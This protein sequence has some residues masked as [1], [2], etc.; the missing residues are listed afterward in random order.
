M[1]RPTNA[2]K[3]LAEVSHLSLRTIMRHICGE[4]LGEGLFRD[5]YVMKQDKRF[6]VKV[7]RDMSTGM[8]ANAT[9]WRNYVDNHEDQ[10]IGPWLAP[11]EAVNETGQILIMRRI[12]HEP[13]VSYPKHVPSCFTDLKRTNYGFLGARFVCCDYSFLLRVPFRMK[14][15]KWWELGSGPVS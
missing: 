9:E 3:A 10:Q 2:S 11:C 12:R 13:L 6:V 8:F 15:A 7:E 14:R 4:Q 1:S 5:V